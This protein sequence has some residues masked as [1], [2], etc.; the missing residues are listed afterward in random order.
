MWLVSVLLT[1]WPNKAALEQSGV[2]RS[3]MLV[4]NP[5]CLWYATAGIKIDQGR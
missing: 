1:E 2:I 4:V 3:G 5:L